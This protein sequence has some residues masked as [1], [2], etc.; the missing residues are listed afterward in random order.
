MR[1]P[2]K[3]LWFFLGALSLLVAYSTLL[4]SSIT[5]ENQK[6]YYD[7]FNY[8]PQLPKDAEQKKIH[9]R[10]DFWISKN[11]FRYHHAII[12]PSS[13][14]KIIDFHPNF[15]AE[16]VFPHL[17]CY[18]QEDLMGSFDT[19]YFQ[20]LRIFEAE[21][22]VYNYDKQT[23]IAHKV[24]FSNYQLEGNQLPIKDSLPQPFLA[25]KASSTLLKFKDH[26]IQAKANHVQ[27]T[28]FNS[29]KKSST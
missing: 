10:K 28:V 24:N 19:G 11:G 21:S 15:V 4:I 7:L 25:G 18:L 9:V 8:E 16:E 29:K 6:E 23:F 2:K 14:V 3:R 27:A 12:S 20:E 5:E 13:K 17:E 26:A 1:M 22:G